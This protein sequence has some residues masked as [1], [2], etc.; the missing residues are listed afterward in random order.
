MSGLPPAS[1]GSSCKD[2][3]R[4]WAS[5]ASRCDRPSVLKFCTPRRGGSGGTSIVT[6]SA[7]SVS[8]RKLRTELYVDA[9]LAM[10]EA[11]FGARDGT[12]G[13]TKGTFTVLS[14]GSGACSAAELRPESGPPS[15]PVSD[16]VPDA[17]AANSAS[18]HDTTSS[19]SPVLAKSSSKSQ[20]PRGSLMPT[21]FVVASVFD[22]IGC[23]LVDS[24]DPSVRCDT[25]A[26]P[27]ARCPAVSL[28]ASNNRCDAVPIFSID[29]IP[30]MTS[31]NLLGD[32]VNTSTSSACALLLGELLK[33]TRCARRRGES[34]GGTKP[35]RLL[36]PSPSS[37]ESESHS[38]CFRLRLPY[39]FIGRVVDNLHII[40]E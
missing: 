21:G 33:S 27:G 4:Y 11:L 15:E 24:F 37:D 31:V 17:T 32:P 14:G 36:D 1:S 8:A 23:R 6:A 9:A 20:G 38:G 3:I 16:P 2:S 7:S 34:C 29:P 22:W 25:T 10:R 5:S 13:G 12:R 35:R 26:S 30:L 19:L 40:W 28:V 39:T 18:I